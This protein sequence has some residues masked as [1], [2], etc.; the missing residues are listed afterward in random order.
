VESTAGFIGR[1]RVEA[2]VERAADG[3]QVAV[4]RGLEDA[5]AVAGVDG[6]LELPP[7]REP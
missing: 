2:V 7:A 4:A 6:G 3:V 1:A 5:P